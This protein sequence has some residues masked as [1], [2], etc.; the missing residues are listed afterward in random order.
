M[1]HLI[2]M[3]ETLGVVSGEK[4]DFLE[5]IEETT[6]YRLKAAAVGLCQKTLGPIMFKILPLL[7][8]LNQK[9]L[10]LFINNSKNS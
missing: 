5:F 2:G 3:L 1:V 4:K 7:P 10:N 9:K 8:L 6:L